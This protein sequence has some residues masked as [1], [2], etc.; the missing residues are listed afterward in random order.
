MIF[1]I[2]FK[3]HL[4]STLKAKEIVLIKRLK[5]ELEI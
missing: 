2:I 3:W 5:M 4:V 1:G